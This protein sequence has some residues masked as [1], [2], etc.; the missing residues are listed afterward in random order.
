MSQFVIIK[1]ASLENGFRL[2]GFGGPVLDV[3]I[4]TLLIN[5]GAY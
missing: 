4:M 2:L 3:E 1:N 5:S